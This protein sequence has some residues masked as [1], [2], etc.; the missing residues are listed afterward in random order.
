MRDE[1]GVLVSNSLNNSHKN[2]YNSSNIRM[3]YCVRFYY[4]IIGVKMNYCFIKRYILFVINC[5][6]LV[7]VEIDVN[8]IRFFD[9]MDCIT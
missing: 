3:N 4:S 9:K 6:V 2:E 1:F 8:K 5:L 7:F